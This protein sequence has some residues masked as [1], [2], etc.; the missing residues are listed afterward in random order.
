MKQCMINEKPA[1]MIAREHLMSL[2]YRLI[3]K[4]KFK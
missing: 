4:G 2:H 1:N 3:T